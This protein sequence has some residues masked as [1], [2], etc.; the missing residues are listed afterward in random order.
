MRFS[1]ATTTIRMAKTGQAKQAL[2]TYQ[3]T[4]ERHDSQ[5]TRHKAQ[6]T[7]CT[8]MASLMLLLLLS[9]VCLQ[10]Y[11]YIYISIYICMYVCA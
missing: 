4:E 3:R 2:H 8:K 7:T 9:F 5:R 10:T 6:D 11:L 1:T